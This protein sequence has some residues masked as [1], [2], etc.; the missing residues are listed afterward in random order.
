[1]LAHA[2]GAGV[3]HG[4][5]AASGPACS[6][7]SIARYL[8]LLADFLLVRTLRPWSGDVGR[9]LVKAPKVYLCDSGI[10]HAPLDLGTREQLIASAPPEWL[11]DS[12][13]FLAI[14]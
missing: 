14:C 3:E 1:M 6:G 9:R 7:Q 8:D 12:H 4:A 11:G 2:Q 5:A 13:I 10:A